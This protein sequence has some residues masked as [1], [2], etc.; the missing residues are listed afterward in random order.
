M[1]SG[2]DAVLL[3]LAFAVAVVLAFAEGLVLGLMIGGHRCRLAAADY[4]P[5]ARHRADE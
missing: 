5:S 4:L 1:R 2:K 3:T